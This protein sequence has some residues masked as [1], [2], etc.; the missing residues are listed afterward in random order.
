MF[1][2][3]M[4]QALHSKFGTETDMESRTYP[5]VTHFEQK[6]FKK[7]FLYAIRKFVQMF[8]LSICY[9]PILVENST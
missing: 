8:S 2:R 1:T 3:S 9:I 6:L 5:T 7:A 4:M